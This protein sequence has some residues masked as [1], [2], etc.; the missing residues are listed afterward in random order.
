MHFRSVLS[1]A[2]PNMTA[3]HVELLAYAII[4]LFIFLLFG[5][6]VFLAAIEL[7]ERMENWSLDRYALRRTSNQPNSAEQS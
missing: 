2:N 7:Y 6:A 4:G 3:V 1:A 5:G